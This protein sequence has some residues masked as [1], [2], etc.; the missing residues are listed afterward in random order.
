M[1]KRI[2]T[3]IAPMYNQSDY[4]SDLETELLYGEIVDVIKSK[5]SWCYCKNISDNYREISKKLSLYNK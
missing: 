1:K 4:K 5:N 3:S 2:I